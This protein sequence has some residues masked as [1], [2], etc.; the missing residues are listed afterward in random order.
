[1]KLSVVHPDKEVPMSST[2]ISQESEIGIPGV[3]DEYLQLIPLSLMDSVLSVYFP[4]CRYLKQAWS[5]KTLGSITTSGKFSIGESFYIDSTGH[6]NAVEANICLNQIAYV[7]FADFLNRRDSHPFWADVGDFAFED[8]GPNQLANMFIVS[9][10]T[11]FRKAIDGAGFFGQ[12]RIR[13]ISSKMGL[14]F[15]DC[16]FSFSQVDDKSFYG[17]VTF[18]VARD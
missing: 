1:M 9:L 14:I 15:F 10:S 18:A 3:A 13:K 6:F 2:T 11:K 5:H 7:T 8:F 17:N 12:F 16:D 4:D